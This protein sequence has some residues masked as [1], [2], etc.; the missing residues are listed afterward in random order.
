MIVVVGLRLRKCDSYHFR[1]CSLRIN[2]EATVYYQLLER[3]TETPLSVFPNLE[4]VADT[5]I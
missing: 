3:Y 2:P 1:N 4:S 5:T